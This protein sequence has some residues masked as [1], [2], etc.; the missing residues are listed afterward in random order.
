MEK[1]INCN[2][3]GK[4]ASGG[5][6]QDKKKVDKPE[7]ELVLC[8]PTH[9]VYTIKQPCTSCHHIDYDELCALT[10]IANDVMKEPKYTIETLIELNTSNYAFD[11]LLESNYIRSES[12]RKL[13]DAGVIAHAKNV[14]VCAAWNDCQVSN[15]F[16]T[17][18]ILFNKNNSKLQ[19]FE[20]SLNLTVLENLPFEMIIRRQAI[21]EFDLWNRTL[22]KSTLKNITVPAKNTCTDTVVQGP[23]VVLSS[24]KKRN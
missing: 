21:N 1:L 2:A 8:R 3:S 16:I 4:A 17:V 7:S 6:A 19:T 11:T 14:N 9:S 5:A 22:D 20:A 23:G 15:K 13:L 18:T 10:D 12:V 24:S